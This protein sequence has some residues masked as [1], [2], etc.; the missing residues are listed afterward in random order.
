MVWESDRIIE[1]EPLDEIFRSLAHDLDFCEA[2]EDLE[3]EVRSALDQV[4]SISKP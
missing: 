2:D 4:E 3:R 1:N